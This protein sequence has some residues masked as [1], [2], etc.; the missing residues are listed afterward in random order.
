M[1]RIVLVSANRPLNSGL[2]NNFFGHRIML[3]EEMVFWL[4]ISDYGR[5]EKTQIVSCD[6]YRNQTIQ[7]RLEVL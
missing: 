4:A 6:D 3:N 1:R 5:F 2:R 7:K